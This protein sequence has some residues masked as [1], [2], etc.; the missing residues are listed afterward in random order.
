MTGKAVNLPT[1]P[2][3]AVDYGDRAWGPTTAEIVYF[4]SLS[5]KVVPDLVNSEKPNGILVRMGNGLLSIL[6]HIPARV[7][8]PLVATTATVAIGTV[9]AACGG[10]S[11]VDVPK[12]TA[13]PTQEPPAT[14]TIAPT[15]TPSPE[16]TPTTERV[17]TPQE[18]SQ[19]TG[20]ALKGLPGVSSEA[21]DNLL[22]I[23]YDLTT[24]EGKKMIA[25][26]VDDAY[27][28]MGTFPEVQTVVQI[29]ISLRGGEYH[30]S[31]GSAIDILNEYREVSRGLDNLAK[32]YP[33]NQLLGQAGK[34]IDK[35]L[36]SGVE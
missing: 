13:E 31:K 4:N 20:E 33:G 19:L 5:D 6:D 9:A 35:F 22:T 1:L 29:L 17:P 28:S 32:I 25:G 11:K 26:A 10:G 15:P 24:E 14:E 18:I 27:L 34:E 7:R 36:L 3:G 2:N 8:R 12:N 16:V 30:V 23:H 21:I